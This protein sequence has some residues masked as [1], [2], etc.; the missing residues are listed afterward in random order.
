MPSAGPAALLQLP[1]GAG[2]DGPGEA[3]MDL[4]IFWQAHLGV[5]RAHHGKDP[6]LGDAIFQV[7]GISRELQDG[8]NPLLAPR[9]ETMVELIVGIALGDRITPRVLKGA[10]GCR[11]STICH[12]PE[13]DPPSTPTRN[14][15]PKRLE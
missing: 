1:L 4:H 5:Q 11:P 7:L 15:P 12:T 2:Q 9:N 3:S 13:W 6:L 8:R 14:P 10:N